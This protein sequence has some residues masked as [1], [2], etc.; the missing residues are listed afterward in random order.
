MTKA[1]CNAEEGRMS[2]S[3]A[4]GLSISVCVIGGFAVLN[5]LRYLSQ[6][7]EY[8]PRVTAAE[9]GRPPGSGYVPC[10]IPSTSSEI[11]VLTHYD[12]MRSKGSFRFP[13]SDWVNMRTNLLPIAS[14]NASSLQGAYK[15]LAWTWWFPR[16]F[17]Q[18]DNK[19][20]RDHGFQLYR[21]TPGSMEWSNSLFAITV[22]AVN[23]K[24]GRCFFWTE[25]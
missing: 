11:H 20:A 5:E 3:V 9:N 15:G 8:I 10:W 19:V 17:S 4:R 14:S 16:F 13:A 6:F 22:F 24:E 23:P 18:L 12:M 2:R 1:N 25:E 7:S 21:A